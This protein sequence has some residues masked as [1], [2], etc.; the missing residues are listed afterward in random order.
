MRRSDVRDVVLI[1]AAVAASLV[2]GWLEPRGIGPYITAVLIAACALVVGWRWHGLSKAMIGGIAIFSGLLLLL[3]IG[4][5]MTAV[6]NVLKGSSSSSGQVVPVRPL[7][8]PS[9]TV[10]KSGRSIVNSC[11]RR[12]CRVIAA[13]PDGS[14][15]YMTCYVDA[16]SVTDRYKSS[17]WFLIRFEGRGRPVKHESGFVHSSDVVDQALT[18]QCR[19]VSR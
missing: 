15:V 18:P 3:G 7:G 17:R 13:L 16:E 1:V 5:W 9:L 19:N 2:A 8:S 12:A 4:D 10:S 6:Q 11:P 14:T